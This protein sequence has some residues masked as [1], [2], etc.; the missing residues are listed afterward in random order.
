MSQ[1]SATQ[2]APQSPSSLALDTH[3]II[4]SSLHFHFGNEK[5][6]TDPLVAKQP[7][8]WS[9]LRFA[10]NDESTTLVKQVNELDNSKLGSTQQQK[11]LPEAQRTQGIASLT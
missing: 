1:M 4:S 3:L 11:T 9:S 7:D 6:Y 5:I 2:T 8:F 10:E